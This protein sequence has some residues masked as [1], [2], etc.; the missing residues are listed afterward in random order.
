[1]PDDAAQARARTEQADPLRN[2][3]AIVGIDRIANAWRQVPYARAEHYSPSS[4][5][6]RCLDGAQD[7]R[8]VVLPIVG[9][10]AAVCRGIDLEFRGRRRVRAN[11]QAVLERYPADAVAAQGHLIVARLQRRRQ[12]DFRDVVAECGLKLVFA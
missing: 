6:A 5:Q 1:M 4:R 10:T 9:T 11:F 2:D 7:A 3:D 12:P 8:R